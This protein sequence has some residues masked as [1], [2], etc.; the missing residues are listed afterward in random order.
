MLDSQL[1]YGWQWNCHSPDDLQTNHLLGDNMTE[2][3]QIQAIRKH[4]E[5]LY[6]KGW[7]YVVECFDDG[8]L[9]DELSYYGM[10]LNKTIVGI[11]G[12]VNMYLQRQQE[13]R[14]DVIDFG[15]TP[16]F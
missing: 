9:L 10:D 13:Q 3:E 8:D 11:Q 4:A 12:Y 5:A 1:N 7:D 2:Q 6:D 14:A 16:N 15:E